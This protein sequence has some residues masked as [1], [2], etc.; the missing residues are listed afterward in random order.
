MLKIEGDKS[1][2]NFLKILIIYLLSDP[3]IMSH[4]VRK[5]EENGLKL[6]IRKKKSPN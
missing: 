4:S 6:R 3:L 2:V 1:N 5:I